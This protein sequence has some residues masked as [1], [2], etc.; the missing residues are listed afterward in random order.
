MKFKIFYLF[1]VGLLLAVP[2]MLLSQDNPQTDTEETA[3]YIS[4]VEG[5]VFFQN[6]EKAEL[7]MAVKQGDELNTEKGRIEVDLGEGNLVRLDQHTRVVFTSLQKEQVTLSIWEGSLYLQLK[8]QMVKV[9]S[10]QEEHSFQEEGLY[11][12][13]VG[14]NKTEVYK[15]PRVVDKFDSWSRRREEE[16]NRREYE[17]NYSRAYPYSGWMGWSWYPLGWNIGLYPLWYYYSYYPYAWNSYWYW[18]NWYMGWHPYGYLTSW[19][20]SYYPIQGYYCNYHPFNYGRQTIIRK[21]QLQQRTARIG[22]LNAIPKQARSSGALYPSRITSRYIKPS[23]SYTSGSR[24]SSTLSSRFYSRPSFSRSGIISSR[25]PSRSF[26][27]FSF[28]SSPSFRAG[29]IGRTSIQSGRIRR[30]N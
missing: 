25:Q 29:Q 21:E 6:F 1:T 13:D 22:T 28:R 20:Y 24:I 23:S 12:V 16:I 26:N 19:Y 30:P 4:N 5:I 8:N 10:P 27:S 15:D 18:N 9:R 17:P 2:F 3:G 7:D 14:K 11:R